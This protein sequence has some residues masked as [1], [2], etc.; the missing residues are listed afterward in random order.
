MSQINENRRAAKRTAIV[1]AAI[2]VSV[3]VGFLIMSIG[4]DGLT[5]IFN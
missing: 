5:K 2:A 3:F 4:L 1:L